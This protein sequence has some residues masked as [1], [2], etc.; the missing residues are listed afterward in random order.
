M[1]DITDNIAVVAAS[2]KRAYSDHIFGVNGKDLKG[3]GITVKHI[4]SQWV[5]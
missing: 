4:L 5:C 2:A 3:R 1:L